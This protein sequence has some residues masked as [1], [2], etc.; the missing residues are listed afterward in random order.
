MF[1]YHRTLK[2]TD[3]FLKHLEPVYVLFL[4]DRA[5]EVRTI[6]LSRLNDLI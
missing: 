4:K 5:A 3:I 1:Y 2:N 6:G